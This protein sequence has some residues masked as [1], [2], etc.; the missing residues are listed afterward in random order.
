MR[1]SSNAAHGSAPSWNTRI[2]KMFPDRALQAEPSAFVS[3]NA[4]ARLSANAD[5]R[6]GRV[7]GVLRELHQL[8]EV[9]DAA[10]SAE[11]LGSERA[12]LAMAPNEAQGTTAPNEARGAQVA[13]GLW[14]AKKRPGNTSAAPSQW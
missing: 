11:L 2:G 14:V 8:A 10:R 6:R 1:S 3:A 5:A 7:T 4:D 13:F 9:A 12:P